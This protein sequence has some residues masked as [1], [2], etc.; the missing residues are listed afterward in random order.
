MLAG[1]DLTTIVSNLLDNAVDAVLEL[2]EE[3]RYIHF[4]VAFQMGEIMIH[5]ENP[6][7]N[8]L[9]REGN[10]VVSTKEGHFGLGLKNV[11]MVVKK[12]KGDFKTDVEDGIFTAAITIPTATNF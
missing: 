3:Q 10:T 12:Y 4:A 8:D 9:K 5:V 2:P 6:T 7:K 1:V 11:E